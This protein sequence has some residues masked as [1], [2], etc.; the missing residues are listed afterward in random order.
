MSKRR[1][2]KQKAPNLPEETLA[3][4]RQQAQ[5]PAEETETDEIDDV[6]VVAEPVQPVAKPKAAAPA[7]KESKTAASET[8]VSQA[9]R[10]RSARERGERKD[11]PLTS[12]EIAELLEHPTK[13]VTEEELSEQYGYVIADLRSMA[14]LAAVLVVMLIV[15]AQFI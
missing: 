9:K 2:R 10:R 11:K 13:T 14:I 1:S 4:A 8:A 6:E 3:R 15:L 7:R 12:L 5:L